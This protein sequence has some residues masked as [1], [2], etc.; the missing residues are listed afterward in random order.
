MSNREQPAP[1]LADSLGYLLKHAH[2][3][4]SERSDKALAPLGIDSKELGILV[5]IAGPDPLSQQQV[6]QRLGVDRTTMVAMLDALEGKG[7]VSRHPQAED[8]RRNVVELTEAGRGTFQRA[9]KARDGAERDYL[10][11]LGGPDSQQLRRSL[12]T[13]VA[14]SDDSSG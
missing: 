12:K 10:A 14:R 3:Q 9:I 4:L 6:A 8:R 5:V 13:V 11:S 7:I 2:L 1:E